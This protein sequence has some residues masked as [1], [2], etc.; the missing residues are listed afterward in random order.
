MGG[1]QGAIVRLDD[2]NANRQSQP[3]AAAGTVAGAFGAI[4]TFKQF[5][6]LRIL[7]AR[8]GVGKGEGETAVFLSAGDVQSATAVGVSQAVLQQVVEELHQTIFIAKHHRAVRQGE[9][10]GQVAAGKTFAESPA[11]N[12]QNVDHVH[13]C[14][15]IGQRPFV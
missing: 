12:L 14:F 3:G 10:N 8:S 13:R 6:Q 15:L 4:K 1:T 7:H 2:I 11:D 5:F 9:V